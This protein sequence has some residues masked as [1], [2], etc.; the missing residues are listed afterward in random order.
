M[1]KKSKL[2]IQCSVQSEMKRTA[3]IKVESSVHINVHIN[4][5]HENSLC[6]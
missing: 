2:N 4:T 1:E 3:F 5:Q 6:E